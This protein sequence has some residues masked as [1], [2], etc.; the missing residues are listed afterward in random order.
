ME[1]ILLVAGVLYLASKWKKPVAKSS[2]VVGD[3]LYGAGSAPA[4]SLSPVQTAIPIDRAMQQDLANS[5]TNKPL[6]TESILPPFYRTDNA[7]TLTEPAT[8]ESL[9]PLSKGNNPILIVEETG[10]IVPP[11]L[12]NNT[13]HNNIIINK[14]LNVDD[15]N[16]PVSKIGAPIY[17]S[18]ADEQDATTKAG[19]GAP[20]VTT[21]S[22]QKPIAVQAVPRLGGPSSPAKAPIIQQ[23]IKVANA[24]IE[25]TVTRIATSTIKKATTT[26]TMLT[27]KLNANSKLRAL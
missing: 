4:G 2:I 14:T 6:S 12:N 17:T 19:I 3:N 8:T 26:P 23:P 10:Y 20:V 15:V 13:V 25:N 24:T 5:N 16:N 22:T 11:S 27:T 18:I 9:T 21:A 7:A 1:I